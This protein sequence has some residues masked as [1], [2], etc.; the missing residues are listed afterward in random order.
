MSLE[1]TKT[2]EVHNFIYDEEQIKQFVDL[3][4][5]KDANHQMFISARHKYNKDVPF[6]ACNI[7]PKSFYNVDADHFIDLIRKYE[8]PVGSYDDR[9]VSLPTNCLVV[10]CTTNAREGKR[11]AQNFI[12]NC[13]NSVFSGDGH[14]FNHLYENLNSAIMS[15]KAKTQLTTIDIDSKDEYKEVKEFLIVENI[16]PAAVIETRGGYHVLLK[17]DKNLS[18]VYKS[19]SAKHTMGDTFCPIPGT[20]QGGFPVRFISFD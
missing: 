4:G 1:L 18:N 5:T 16:V 20:L 6:K 10:Y 3:I 17:T 13:M 8:L 14:I 2:V 9:G 15:S 12:N 7:S 19:F 11:A